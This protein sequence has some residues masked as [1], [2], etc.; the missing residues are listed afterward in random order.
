MGFSIFWFH[1]FLF[2]ELV[3][4]KIRFGH[5][6]KTPTPQLDIVSF[7]AFC[8]AIYFDQQTH[9]CTC[10][11]MVE[12]DEKISK[13]MKKV[14]Y[15]SCV[16]EAHVR[17]ILFHDFQMFFIVFNIVNASASMHLLVKIHNTDYMLFVI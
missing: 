17:L 11:H 8:N 10:V 1:A 14:P 5:L 12:N 15:P 4:V 13:I 16:P 9:A 2:P 3:F 6:R 7:T